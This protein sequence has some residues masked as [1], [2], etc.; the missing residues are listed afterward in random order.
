MTTAP[1]LRDVLYHPWMPADDDIQERALWARH[2]PHLLGPGSQPVRPGHE[3]RL[4]LTGVG[5]P[6]LAVYG[7]RH[8][9]SPREP[10]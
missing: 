7:L 2:W 1:A 3:D 10:C 5:A 4:D 8:A 6:L 9:E